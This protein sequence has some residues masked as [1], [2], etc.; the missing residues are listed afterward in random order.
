MSSRTCQARLHDNYKTLNRAAEE[1]GSTLNRERKMKVLRLDFS[2]AK[3]VGARG[4]RIFFVDHWGPRAAD[5][6]QGWL[7]LYMLRF[8]EQTTSQ[9]LEGFCCTRATDTTVD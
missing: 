8:V 3:H 5:D 6:H 7:S 4:L 1:L 2:W 9:A